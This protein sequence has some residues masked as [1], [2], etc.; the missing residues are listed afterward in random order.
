MET[1]ANVRH[2]AIFLGLLAIAQG[3][4]RAQINACDLNYDGVVNVVDVQLAV[5][6]ALGLTA[7]TTNID[8]SEVCNVVVVERVTNAALGS[9]CITNH[10]VSLSWTASSSS[11]V[12]GYNLYRGTDSTGPFTKVNLSLITGTSVVDNTAAPG[13]TYYYVAT[14]VDSSGAESDYSSPPVQAVVPSP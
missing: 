12:A 4:T 2:L 10:W 7:C 8:G 11:N 6:M 5:K 13:Q 3:S 9:E 1:K 14:A